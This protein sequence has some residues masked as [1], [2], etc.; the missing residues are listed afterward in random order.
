MTLAP[1]K[2]DPRT[3]PCQPNRGF[4][5]AF[6]PR[7][8]VALAAG[9]VW[10]GPAWWDPRF[11]WIMLLWDALVV[12]AWAAD[13]RRLPKPAQVEITREWLDP[14]SLDSESVVLLRVENRSALSFHASLT[15]T[16]PAGWRETP[17]Q[18]DLQLA[19]GGAAEG[20]YFIR[21]RQR[22]DAVTGTV[23][24]RVRSAFQLAE[25]WMAADLAQTTRVYPNL[26]ASRSLTLHLIRSRQMQTERRFKVQQGRGREFESLREYRA[27]DEKRDICWTATARRARLVTKTYQHERSQA[28]ILVVDAGRLM[29]ARSGEDE[30]PWTKLDYAASAAL[31]LAQVAL[32]SGDRTGLLAYGR[33]LQARV[34]PGR[35]TGHFRAMLDSLAIVRGEFSEA[36]HSMAADALLQMQSRRSLVLWLTDLAETAATP[37][38]IEA[39]TRVASRHLLLFVTMAQPKLRA[40]TEARPTNAAEMY[41]YVAAL[42]MVQRRELLL[43]SLRERGAL[44]LDLDP[45]QTAALV[46]NEYLRIKERGLL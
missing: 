11:V 36:A 14:V 24:L 44:V 17:P 20:R 5:F 46:V 31:A 45:G 30:S 28:V 40:V 42:E 38:V 39:A 41:R 9:A 35:G 6:G 23:Y 33:K 27:G 19:P 4:A 1:L 2:P 43:G 21:P 37:E 16:V 25:G 22:G 10:L 7:F 8:F 29:L 18:M 32:Y 12:A 26:T 3:S 34:K 15:D 13:C